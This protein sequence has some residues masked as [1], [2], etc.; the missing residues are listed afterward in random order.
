MDEDTSQV[1]GALWT[2]ELVGR[3]LRPRLFLSPIELRSLFDSVPRGSG[4]LVLLFTKSGAVD[5]NREINP[6]QSFVWREST[7]TVE[8][9]ADMAGIHE[10]LQLGD[11]ASR[12]PRDERD[13][14]RLVLEAE[15]PWVH[16]PIQGSQ[17]SITIFSQRCEPAQT[18]LKYFTP[19]SCQKRIFSATVFGLMSGRLCDQSGIFQ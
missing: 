10:A 17:G 12:H 2:G 7:R 1:G 8:P 18:A 4:D 11:A 9:F 5:S 19:C 13:L 14:R 15:G 3:F 6:R 16:C